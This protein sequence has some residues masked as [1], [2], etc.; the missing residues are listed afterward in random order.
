MLV[1][2][3]KF[4]KTKYFMSNTSYLILMHLACYFP[5]TLIHIFIVSENRTICQLIIKYLRIFKI[6]IEEII[7]YSKFS[8]FLIQNKCLFTFNF[9]TLSTSFQ[10]PYLMLLT[11][12]LRKTTSSSFFSL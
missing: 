7:K 3:T 11:H 6:F 2:Y 12:L 1:L 4:C 5:F 8:V 10:S 9:S